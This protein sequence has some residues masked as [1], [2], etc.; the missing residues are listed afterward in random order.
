MTGT[1]PAAS[2]A[3]VPPS[4]HA[5]AASEET[6]TKSKNELKNEAKRLEK[7]AK[8]QAKQAKQAAAKSTE[9]PQKEAAVVT[10][11]APSAVKEAEPFVNLTPKGEKKDM[12]TP[13]APAYNPKAVE[14]AWYD[15][16]ESEGFF[17]PE[18]KPDGTVKDEGT[19]VVSIPPPNVTGSLHIGHALTNAIQD[20]MIRWNRMHGKTT[21]W[22]PGA[23]HAGISTQVVVEKKLMRERGIT[24]HD[25]GREAFLEEVFKW[26]D[27][28]IDTI[29]NQLRR[30]GSSFDW[31]RDHFTM[32]E[33][34]SNAVREA[35]VRM[36]EDGTIYRANRLVNWCT[37]LK[38]AL[39]NL[40][41]ENKELNGSTFM[42]VP[43]HDP[44]KTYEFGVLVSFAYQVEN[45]DERIVVATT[46]LETMLGDTAIAVH[47]SDKRYQHLHGKYVTHPFQNRRI[48]ILADEYPDP[49]FGTGAVKITPAH[50]ANDYIVGQRQKLE[51]I[52]I[53][54]DE[55]KINENGAPFV[56][57]QRFDAR[58]AILEALKEKGLYVSTEPNKQVLPICTRSGN[59][60]EPL[61]KPQ[62]WVNCQDMAKDAMDAVRKGDLAIAPALSE[63]E[64]FRWL[65]NIQDW[66]IS[67]QLWWGHR[68]PA[69]YVHID[70]DENDRDVSNRWVSGRSE[71]EARC[72]AI[73]K[74]AEV[75]PSKMTLF[76]DEDVL[77]TWFSSGLW[78]FSVLGWPA[79]TRDM[80]LYFPNTLLETG[81]DILFF[82]VARMVMM[83]LKLEGVVPFKQVFCHAM[84]R[85]AHGRKMSKSLGNVIDPIDVIEGVTLEYLQNR[86]ESGNLDPREL[87][88]AREGQKKDFPNGIPECGTDALRFGL[89]AYSAGGRDINLDILRV[90]GYRKFCNKLWNATRFALMKLGEDYLP[91][92]A[93][94]QLNGDESL[95]D[96]WILAKLNQAITNTNQSMEQM[97][98]MQAT[99]AMYQFWL[100]E[101]CDVYLEV[102][103]PVIDGDDLRAKKAAQDVLYICLEHGLKLLHP[104]M[105]FVTEELYQRLPRR[106]GDQPHTIMMARYPKSLPI[107]EQHQAET[108]FE[109]VNEVIRGIRSVMTEYNIRSNATVYVKAQSTHLH[110]VFQKQ[111]IIVKTLAKGTKVFETV[112]M[113]G[114]TPEG[115]VVS[116][117]PNSTLYLLVKGQMDFDVEIAKLN[118]KI[119]KITQV[120]KN[121]CAIMAGD[122]YAANVK[123]EVKESDLVKLNGY[124]AEI[125]TLQIALANFTKLKSE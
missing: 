100:H 66:C 57:L 32:D 51:N 85:D 20:A 39:S 29:Y 50:D 80:E 46:R 75:D 114:D 45:S 81:W 15:W 112:P 63:R 18:L 12:S 76:Q 110:D 124:E 106:E 13:M 44:S 70:G 60:I 119:S 98:F 94:S 62:W 82:W 4:P 41:V 3:G 5:G 95:V 83:S 43:D 117:L 74:F 102:C 7:L 125:A 16:W 97:N 22:I 8:F 59:I 36:H 10:K 34:L 79:K 54:T 71:E 88:R 93:K 69:Y 64:W 123:P 56:G 103:K 9:K 27:A 87:V 101:L 24:R 25:I 58:L 78:P 28:N 67:R 6:T 91:R 105:P 55:G 17:K 113:D 19:F 21:L 111:Q 89:L 118:G 90:D 107:W 96:L 86:L 116:I 40:E 84:I 14:A 115:C 99:T 26:K 122:G 49:E 33:G 72:K 52:T 121:L 1:A 77:D 92:A 108:D 37:K 120:S 11:P 31:S 109:A 61:L 23:D 2:E 47:P 104:I 53:F 73:K 42:T 48:P 68:V 38:T 30:L 65:E 35:F